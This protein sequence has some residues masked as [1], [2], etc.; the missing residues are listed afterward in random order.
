MAVT[1]EEIKAALYSPEVIYDQ[2]DRPG[3]QVRA[4]GRIELAVEGRTVVTVLHRTVEEYARGD[5]AF[6]IRQ[7]RGHA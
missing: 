3:R 5:V 7:A 1:A 6:D 2:T 4:G